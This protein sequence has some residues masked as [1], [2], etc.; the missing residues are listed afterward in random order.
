MREDFYYPSEGEGRIHACR[1]SSGKEPKAILQIVHGI[2]EHVGRYDHFA[3]YMTEHGFLVVA[4]DH[5]GHGSSGN[6]PGYFHGGWHTAVED[7][8]RLL[9]D[10]RRS[11]PNIPYILLGHSMGSFMVRTLLCKYPEL[12]IQAAVISGTAWQPAAAMPLIVCI[13]EQVCAHFGETLPN[14][15]LQ[16][17]VFGTYNAKV[18]HPRTP[19]DWVCRV[20]A[21]VD[22]HPM[23][24]GFR[25]TAGLLRDMMEGINFIERPGHLAAM[26][27]ELPVFFIAGGADPVGNYGKGI[28]ACIR[29]FRKAGMQDIT[30]RIYP[31]CRHE[32]LNEINR[33]E[34]YEDVL[35]WIESKIG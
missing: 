29:A 4:E 10:T 20:N 32:I 22:E 6:L 26:R 11:Y 23:N 28:D 15:K 7:T 25:P 30:K 12:P 35:Q 13:M 17:L 24:H 3:R 27:K 1:W 19:L 16:N 18:E 5:M 34:V 8:R 9:L 21:V 33:E 2:A 14:E 31:L